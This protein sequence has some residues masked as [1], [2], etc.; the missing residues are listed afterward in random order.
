[1]ILTVRYMRQT[2]LVI[3]S[4][5]FVLQAQQY[6]RGVGVYPGDPRQDFAPALVPDTQTYRNLALHRAAYQSSSYDFYQTAQLVTDG[7]KDTRMPRW[8][9]IATSDRGTLTR[10]ER[11]HAVDHNT[12][13]RVSI[14]GAPL[15]IQVETGGG[16]APFEIDRIDVT[17]GGGFGRGGGGQAATGGTIVVSGSDDG[18]G[19][20]ELGRATP[21]PAAT[22][23]PGGGRGFNFAPPTPISVKFAA[24]AHNRFYRVAYAGGTGTQ[25]GVSELAFF[26][27]NER[28]EVG[29]PLH[30]TSAWKPAGKGPEWVYVDLGAACTFDRIVLD[31]IRR[32]AEGSIQVSGDAK[33]WRTLQALPASSGPV[34]DFKLAQPASGRYVR[35]LVTK[36]ATPDGYVL[37]ELEVYGRGGPV[38]RAHLARPAVGWRAP[39]CLPPRLATGGFSYPAAPGESSA[40]RWLRPSARRSPGPASE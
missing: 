5:V 13:T 26:H 16:D 35:V 34:D 3:F 21:P 29:G 14:S 15:W 2:A 28:V 27:N 1:M 12:T 31:W 30:F 20:Q 24:P 7:I 40:F 33:S 37:G 32:A 10:Q 6:T 4:F 25:W 38:A 18:Q 8:F 11:E 36:P 9:S 23:A 22:P 17:A 39:A 19:W